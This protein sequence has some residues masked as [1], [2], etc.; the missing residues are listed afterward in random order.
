M[1]VSKEKKGLMLVVG[2]KTFLQH[3]LKMVLGEKK[4]IFFLKKIKWTIFRL[5]LVFTSELFAS[6]LASTSTVIEAK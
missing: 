3:F 4:N 2:E 1:L 5:F 6:K